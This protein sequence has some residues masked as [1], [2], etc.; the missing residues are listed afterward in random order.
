MH[1]EWIREVHA[2]WKS[3]EEADYDD[4]GCFFDA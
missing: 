1:P 4:V 2:A 3:A